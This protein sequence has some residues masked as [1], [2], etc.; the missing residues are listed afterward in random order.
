MVQ[1]KIGIGLAILLALVALDITTLTRSTFCTASTV[2]PQRRTMISTAMPI[3]KELNKVD[4]R[5][6]LASGS[7]R[8]RELLQLM[9]ITKFDIL[10]SDFDEDLDKSQYPT[11]QE[12]CLATAVCKAKDVVSKLEASSGLQ[13][14]G[15]V[16]VGSDTIVEINGKIL[17]KPRD[18][19]DAYDM[20]SMLS[21]AVHHV[22]TAVTIFSNGRFVESSSAQTA[23]LDN[24][25]SFV[26]TTE[27]KFIELSNEDKLAYVDSKEGFD[28]AGE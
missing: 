8:R 23:P 2:S 21:G 13:R 22:H 16:L 12:Y 9:G 15:T 18:I 28:K 20:I 6:I 4:R 27:V 10:K 5:I 25:K 3:L 17:E 11:A 14:I 1:W 7:P 24:V 19:Q 26:E